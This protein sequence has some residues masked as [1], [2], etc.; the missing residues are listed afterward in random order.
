MT[1]T[2]ATTSFASE[3]QKVAASGAQAV[4]FAGGTGTGT[5]ALWKRLHSADPKLL[6]L[7]SSTWSTANSPPKSAPAGRTRT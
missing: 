2:S 5:A 4:F 6:L 7:G 3:V 1:H